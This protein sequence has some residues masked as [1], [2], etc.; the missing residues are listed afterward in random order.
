MATRQ[1]RQPLHSPTVQKRLT[2]AAAGRYDSTCK[3]LL[4]LG[5]QLGAGAK[6]A[7]RFRFSKGGFHEALHG[8]FGGIGP[9]GARF[10]NGPGKSRPAAAAAAAAWAAAAIAAACRTR[11]TA[12]TAAMAATAAITRI[13]TATAIGTTAS[14]MTATRMPATV[15][16][17]AA[18]PGESGRL[19]RRPDQDHQ[20]GHQSGDLEL[21][22]QRHDLHDSARL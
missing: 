18:H 15:H 6:A 12:A 8:K 9:A 1:P 17:A 19:L 7:T 16:R 2:R 20:P 21:H 5:R 14:G 3:E 4:P 10:T 13:G 22:A 11:T